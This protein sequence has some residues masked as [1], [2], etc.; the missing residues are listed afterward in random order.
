MVK[1]EREHRDNHAGERGDTHQGR[2]PSFAASLCKV[3]AG[4][5]SVVRWLRHG[6]WN[7][8]HRHRTGVGWF[9]DDDPIRELFALLQARPG[10]T[11]KFDHLVERLRILA[12]EGVG[13]NRHFRGLKR[14]SHLAYRSK[15]RHL[16]CELV[17]RQRRRHGPKMPCSRPLRR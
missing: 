1:P 4:G 2:T 14:R 13:T 12:P 17:A 11:W 8:R 10:P 7:M 6:L 3:R 5:R 15:A 9:G 16:R